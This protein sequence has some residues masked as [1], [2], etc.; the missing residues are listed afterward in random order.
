MYAYQLC[1]D[2][3][4]NKAYS[5]DEFDVDK[6]DFGKL[7]LFGSDH[8]LPEDLEGVKLGM[9]TKGRNFT[10]Q[11]VGALSFKMW[12]K[13]FVKFLID[14]LGVKNLQYLDLEIHDLSSKGGNRIVNDF[15]IVNP[16]H[17]VDWIDEKRS[18]CLRDDDG[19]IITV[20]EPKKKLFKKLP[21]M[22][23]FRDTIYSTGIFFSEDL[24]EK[25]GGNGFTGIAFIKHKI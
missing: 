11:I 7:C 2:E 1:Y 24:V 3:S 6:C 22:A 23:V 10:D 14:E 15:Y 18:L 21:E 16:M 17:F 13:R 5:I 9:K 8:F 19:S 12:S 20:T 4:V 25:L